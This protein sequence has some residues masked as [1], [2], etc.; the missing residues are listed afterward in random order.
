MNLAEGM[1]S[2]PEF[3]HDLRLF[4]PQLRSQTVNRLF[5][6]GTPEPVR[7]MPISRRRSSG[8]PF[9]TGTI[10][11]IG[12]PRRVTTTSFFRDRNPVSFSLNSRTPTNWR[13]VV[14]A[15]MFPPL[16]SQ[17]CIIYAIFESFHSE[18]EDSWVP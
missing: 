12:L 10:L 18:S 8:D 13:P 5:A 17:R 11:A 1:E 9:R 4:V 6:L 3:Q 16:W 7:I 2:P 14:L 15:I